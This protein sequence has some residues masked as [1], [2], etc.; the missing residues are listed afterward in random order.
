MISFKPRVGK[1]KT[2]LTSGGF[3]VVIPIIYIMQIDLCHYYY[4][5]D[6]HGYWKKGYI[7]G[8]PK[9][10]DLEIIFRNI[11]WE[12]DITINFVDSFYIFHR[13]NIKSFLILFIDN[14]YNGTR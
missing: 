5:F 2:G 1:A 4:Y 11:L 14:Y 7:K 12:N 10:I 6:V 8:C 13:S 3:T 9:G